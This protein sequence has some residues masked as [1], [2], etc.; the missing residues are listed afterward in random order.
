MLLRLKG[1]DVDH[2][3]MLEARMEAIPAAISEM[4]PAESAAK[5]L[6]LPVWSKSGSL[7]RLICC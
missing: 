7:L 6:D 1:N 3:G 2:P 5:G 4:A